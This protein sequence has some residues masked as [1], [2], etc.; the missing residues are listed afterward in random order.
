MKP[1]T[2]V[3]SIFLL[4]LTGCAHT[5]YQ[6]D[7]AVLGSGY[8]QELYY[9]DP[10]PVYYASQPVI[11]YEE[12]YSSSHSHHRHTTPNW[13]DKDGLQHKEHNR[14][15]RSHIT[16]YRHYEGH[17]DRFRDDNSNRQENDRQRRRDKTYSNDAIVRTANFSGNGAPRSQRQGSDIRQ[18]QLKVKSDLFKRGRREPD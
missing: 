1:L 10:I 8:G 4:G 5:N 12:H 6:Y 2:A 9:A 7:S 13:R 17:A 18:N 3:Y 16:D 14:D 15:T 11:I